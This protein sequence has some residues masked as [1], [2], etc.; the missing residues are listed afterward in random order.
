MTAQHVFMCNVGFFLNHTKHEEPD[1]V[2]YMNW[3]FKGEE[4]MKR[5]S[6]NKEHI[7]KITVLQRCASVNVCHPVTETGGV[8]KRRDERF[9]FPGQGLNRHCLL[10][11]ALQYMELFTLCKEILVLDTACFRMEEDADLTVEDGS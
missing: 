2:S 9:N 3:H 7:Y 10:K 6:I 5:K 8:G 4:I 11:S 1:H